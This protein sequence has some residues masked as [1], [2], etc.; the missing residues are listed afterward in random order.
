[1]E[2]LSARRMSRFE[3]LGTQAAKIVRR[4]MKLNRSDELMGKS[5]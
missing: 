2:T 1:M 5:A 4:Q 3:L